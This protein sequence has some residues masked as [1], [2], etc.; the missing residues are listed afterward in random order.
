MTIRSYYVQLENVLV[1]EDEVVTYEGQSYL[2][3]YD[4]TGTTTS[5]TTT[6]F[7]FATIDAAAKATLDFFNKRGSAG[8][9]RVTLIP[10]ALPPTQN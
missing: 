5:G 7:R 8:V 2:Y 1:T 10:S 3:Q 4:P 6:A 9:V